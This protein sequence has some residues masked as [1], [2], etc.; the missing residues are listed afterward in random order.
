[1]ARFTD[2]DLFLAVADAG[3]FRGAAE[4]LA[5][6][7]STVSRGVQRLEHHLGAAL[8]L[9]DT[10]NLR[11]TDAGTVY[12]RHA[13]RAAVS[14]NEAER[15]VANLADTVTGTLRISC[16]NVVAQ[17]TIRR[18]VADFLRDHPN[19]GID[20]V[21]TARLV[22]PL[23]DD[24]DLAIRVGEKLADSNLRSR[25]LFRTE[26]LAVATPEIAASI[27]TGASVPYIAFRRLGGAP[28]VVPPVA[29]HTRMS[30]DD[31]PVALNAVRDGIGVLVADRATV[32]EDLET[33]QLVAVLPRWKLG[34]F[35]YWAVYPKA[36]R[37]PANLRAF[38]KALTHG[39]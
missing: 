5:V 7:S 12:R 13:Q 10:R 33:G 39:P 19:V 4:V 27:E 8:F 38:L 21:L 14:L 35:T 37:L 23:L 30:A 34:T 15:G 17:T 24:I 31:Y 16:S 1:M 2:V 3:S 11:L 18:V 26:L 29:Y 36:G 28:S 20:L 6:T 22:N 32:A 25:V 9:R